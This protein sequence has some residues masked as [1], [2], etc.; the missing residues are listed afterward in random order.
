MNELLEN[1]ELGTEFKFEAGCMLS[2]RIA[3]YD[4][5][6]ALVLVLITIGRGLT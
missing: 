4:W 3:T 2:G 5:I 1:G 6:G